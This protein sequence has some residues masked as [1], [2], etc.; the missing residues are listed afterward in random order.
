VSGP[1]EA[2]RRIVEEEA[3]ADDLLRAVVT[4]VASTPG[5]SWAGIAFAEGD[6]L[7]LG[8]AA[9]EPDGEQRQRVAI[10]YE[11]TL[12]GELWVD[13][14]AAR[15]ELERIADLVAPYV[16]IGWDTDG[17]AWDP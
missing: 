8:P 3:D 11:G 17:E 4:A 14:V 16:L 6:A 5:I 10:A 9:G 2:A 12:V 1:L 15:D 13:G 7:G